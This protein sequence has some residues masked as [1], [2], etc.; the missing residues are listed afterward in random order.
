MARHGIYPRD[1]IPPVSS[2]Y[3]AGRFGRM[4]GKLPAFSSDTP[5]IRKALLDVGAVD[6]PMDAREDLNADPKELITDLNLSANNSN[7]PTMSAG[8]TFLGQFIDHDMTFDPTSSL[9]RQVD[10]EHIAN[11]RTPS[12]GLDNVYG[13][14][15]GGSPHLYDRGDG[16]KFLLEETGTPGKYD[17]PRN[18][19]MVALIADPRDDENLIISQLQVAFLKFHNAVVDYVRDELGLSGGEVFA[20]AQRIVRWHY[21]W[22]VIHEYLRKTCGDALIDDILANGRRFY[23]W[24]NEPYIPVEFAVGA[25]RF[26]HSQVRPSY[27]ANFAG[28]ADG[29][30]FF[31]MIFRETAAPEND[32]DD[33]SGSVRAPRRFADWPTFFDFGDGQVKPNKKIDTTLSTAL[34]RLPGTVV[35]HPN[36]ASNPSSLA[37]RN[38]LRHLTFSLPSGQRVAKAM[39][40]E[41]L[42]KAQLHKLAPWGLDDN[43]PLW[44]YVLQEAESLASGERL[45]PVGG[46]IV[47]EVMLGLIEGDRTSFLSQEPDWQPFLPT[48]NPAH[49]NERFAMVDLL[50]FAG[51]A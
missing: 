8:M 29:S 40:I 5:R 18:S 13:A 26:G 47:A 41:P 11:F 37:Q 42:T 1:I 21:Q 10:P 27:R 2:Y 31:A 49:R 48:L 44:F 19:Q 9:E 30:P 51:V 12:L 39:K 43:T 33:L 7:S 46:R 32:P 17:V 16:A 50:R 4:F 28:N 6:G 15:P 35:G 22:I 34:F 24:R 45:G 38:L 14:G 3:E 20:E 23:K 25:Y 36:A